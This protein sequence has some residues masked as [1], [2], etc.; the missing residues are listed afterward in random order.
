MVPHGRVVESGDNSVHS[1]PLKFGAWRIPD[2]LDENGRF[3]SQICICSM[4]KE[5]WKRIWKY[6]NIVNV[7]GRIKLSEFDFSSLVCVWLE[8]R[9]AGLVMWL[10]EIAAAKSINT[11]APGGWSD[12]SLPPSLAPSWLLCRSN[13]SIQFNSIVG[14]LLYRCTV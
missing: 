12:M 11:V 9:I 8:S 1:T 10:V 14:A 6:G 5:F 2:L 13:A 7:W 3:K 4:K